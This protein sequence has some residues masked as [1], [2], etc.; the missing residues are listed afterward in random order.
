M[1]NI[2]TSACPHDCPS[3]CVLDIEHNDKS[4]ISIKGNKRNTYTRGV[5]CAKVSRYKERTHNLN[6]LTYPMI[7]TGSK[8]SGNFKRISW[9]YALKTISR[10]LLSL[11]YKYESSVIWPYFYAGTMGLIQR[12]GINRFRNYFEFS[13]QYSTI[14]N[15]LPQA[16]W[17]AGTG[18]LVGSDPREVS[19]SEVI[20]MWGGNPA[21]TQVNFMKHVQNAKKK[22]NASFILIDPYS[23]KTAKLA[24]IHIKVRPGTDGALACA[25]MHN[26]YK[27]SYV[28]IN[29]LKNFTKDYKL[30][31]Q[32]LSKKSPKWA[33]KICGVEED[34]ID[35]I[36]HL[37]G[38]NKK[39]YIR[40]G[41]GFTRQRNGSFNMHAVTCIPTITGSWQYKGG[42]AF[43]TNGDIYKIDKSIIE[44]LEFKNKSIRCLD[45]SRIGPI[46]TN[47]AK[48]LKYGPEIKAIFIQNTNPLVVAPES[49]LVRKGFLRK[50]LFTIVHEQF[51]TDT[52]K[53]ADI[54]LPATSFVEHN[55]IY[56]S[57]GH[58]HM[59]LGPK[60]IK[61]VGESWSNHKLIN[62]LSK[63]MGAKHKFFDFTEEQMID[64]T[65]K[66]S[67]IGN[68]KNIKKKKFIDM[69]PSFKESHFL[70]GFGHND[71]KF[72][73]AP[74]WKKDAKE[75][76]KIYNLPDHYPLIEE[77]D[78]TH[79][80][81]L[82]TAPAH[83]FLNSSFTET[84][85]SISKEGKPTVKIH[86]KDMKNLLLKDNEL[87]LVGNNRGSIKIHTEK[88]EGL[89]EGVIV[90]EGIWPNKYF[91][92]K[93]GVNVLVGSDSPE[94]AGGAVFHDVA[95]WIK[96]L[97]NK[98][99]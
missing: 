30:L 21:S 64:N 91:E 29:Y 53:Y 17:L 40:L 54:L 12:D 3:T 4:I 23:T 57:G 37:I 81:K 11:I 94:P 55:D 72:H 22:S 86:P 49:N 68:L 9:D 60:L 47:D 62:E 61:E 92:G 73:F 13:D 8:G 44:G 89:L 1:K 65:L 45:Q 24:D 71:K 74:E 77:A 27:Y 48:A 88:F 42:G 98:V 28:D 75:F 79:P 41:Y 87:V 20:I 14:C 59:T 76:N 85:S 50:D 43:Y 35:K 66:I 2:S 5:V 69:Q 82:I 78:E 18:K 7:R 19:D 97:G 25:I 10:K 95:V 96:K 46:L 31:K 63:K 80:F 32:H 16:G 33:S 51:L 34:L 38:K 70:N 15:T 52:A 6:R 26:L 56:I 83:N 99:L 90:V 93:M 84:S 58:Q 67:N 39:T 36:S